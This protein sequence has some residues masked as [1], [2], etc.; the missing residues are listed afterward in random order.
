MM[1][2]RDPGLGKVNRAA[3]PWASQRI[4]LGDT[5]GRDVTVLD[6]VQLG[7]PGLLLCLNLS[8]VRLELTPLGFARGSWTL[9]QVCE[10]SP[11]L[12]DCQDAPDGAAVTLPILWIVM[13]RHG[14]RTVAKADGARPIPPAHGCST[15]AYLNLRS[16]KSRA[17]TQ[18]ALLPAPLRVAPLPHPSHP[19]AMGLAC[20][21]VGA[22]P[23]QLVKRLQLKTTHD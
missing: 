4:P 13:C 16:P 3:A 15:S 20:R 1:T 12:F 5:Q 22:W 6:L 11:R 2:S 9:P 18:E 10:L 21:P 17:S 19:R 8:D 7:I 14:M 23:R